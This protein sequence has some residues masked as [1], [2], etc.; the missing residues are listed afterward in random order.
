MLPE[1]F[2]S[3]LGD[4]LPPGEVEQLCDAIENTDPPVAIRFNPFKVS[5]KP[6]GQQ[7]PWSRYGFIL[8]ERPQFTLDPLFH[9][10]AYYVQEPASMFVEYI[11]RSVIKEKPGVR[12]L[13]LCAAPGG[14]TTIYSTL[15]GLEGLVVANE[16]I[17]PRALTLSDNVTKWGLGNVV[18]T[19][20]DPSHF[21][22]FKNYFD[23]V[24]VDAPCSG[25]GMFRKDERA[26]DEWSPDLVKLCAARQRRILSDIWDSLRP[27]GI[28][29]Y[30]TCTYNRHENEE[31]IQWLCEEFDC[32]GVELGVPS[33]WNIAT[34]NVPAENGS[35]PTF[36]FYPHRTHGEGFF[37][38][39][40]R[41]GGQG[42]RPTTPKPRRTVFTDVPKGVA[43]SLCAWFN[44]PEFMRFAQVGDNIYAYYENTFRDIKTIAETLSVVS[45][46]VLAGQ[47]FKGSLKPEHPLALFHDLNRENVMVSELPLDEALDFLRKQNVSPELLRE[48]INLITHDGFNIGW[49]K[50]IGHRVNNMYPKELRIMNL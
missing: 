22:G 20:N 3:S 21:S 43:K 44:Q 17:R 11:Y 46:G 6:S 27:G 5:E 14:K 42:A 26:R 39:V 50:R 18:V 2:V 35:I 1:E 34:G 23:I 16:V 28:L 47:L 15:V 32:E 29:I 12:L 25:E 10:G 7:L 36:R 41:K 37:A 13:D 4:I 48:G 8:E 19:N 33:G 24:A 38:A 45:S 49:A 31:N 40:V 9:A 30:S